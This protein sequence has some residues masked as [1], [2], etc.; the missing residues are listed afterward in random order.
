MIGFLI[1]LAPYLPVFLQ[2]AG[3]LISLFGTSKANLQ[4]Y[5][6]MIQKN[7]DSGLIT[8][9]TAQKLQDFHAQLLADYEK[10]NPTIPPPA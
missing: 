4:A 10:K 1:T 3:Y 9:E 2:I 6:D 8:V 5:Q 7:K